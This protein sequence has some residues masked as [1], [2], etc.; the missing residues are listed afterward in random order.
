MK[1]AVA[2]LRAEPRTRLFFAA[3]GQS[4]IGTGAA[5]IALLVIAFDRFDSAWGISLV[6][7][8]DFLPAMLLG[9]LLGAAVDRWSRRWCAVLGDVLRAGAFVGI[10]FVDSFE[11]TLA[12]ALIAGLGTAIFRPAV[13]SGLPSLVAPE[14]VPAATSV[15]GA[16]TDAGYILGPAAAAAVLAT[17]GAEE[18]MAVNGITFVLSAFIVAA[19]PLDRKRDEAQEPDRK[20]SLWAEARDG[21]RVL[22]TMPVIRIVIFGSSMG[23]LFGGILNVVE[24]PFATDTLG[25]TNAGYS[26]LVAIFGIGFISGSLG[27][28]GGG[29]AETLKKRWLAGLFI[30]GGSAVA[31]GALPAF[32]LAAVGFVVAGFGNGLSATHQRLLIQDQVDAGLQGRVFA[33]SDALM[34]WGIATAFL[35]A[36]LLIEALGPQTLMV[37]TGAG[38]LLVGTVALVALARRSSKHAGAGAGAE[39]RPARGTELGGADR[40]ADAHA[41]QQRTDIAG[42]RDRWLALLDDLGDRGDDRRVELRSGVRD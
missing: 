23:M 32:A 39:A 16:V 13:L 11:A 8:A 9:P 15:Y 28:A 19:T 7:L 37:L 40:L 41:R 22:K 35:S 18:L 12:L 3:L 26:V 25:T 17:F 14:R 21:L 29:S 4:S 27:G 42:G 33:V 6:L 34:S 1:Q 24:L 30:M 10:A 31:I 36:G 2:L 5:Y 38:E 20:T